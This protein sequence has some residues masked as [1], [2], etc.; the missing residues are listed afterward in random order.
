LSPDPANGLNE[1]HTMNKTMEYMA[2]GRPVIAFDIRETR[3][4]AQEA[5]LYA[6]PNDVVEF[7]DRIVALLD[8]P[9]LRRRLGDYGRQRVVDELGW[10]HTHRALLQAYERLGPAR[11]SAIATRE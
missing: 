6:A 10:K 11:A 2:M 1:F 3:F 7:A 8:D 5:A 9:E 4:S